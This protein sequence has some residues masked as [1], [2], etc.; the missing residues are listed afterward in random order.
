MTQLNVKCQFVK[1]TLAHVEVDKEDRLDMILTGGNSRDTSDN[2]EHVVKNMLKGWA[3]Y[4]D[5]HKARFGSGIGEDSF[6][7]QYWESMG[8]ALLALLNGEVGRLDCGDM[9][10][11]IRQCLTEEGFDG[12]NA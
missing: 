12:D 1:D 10:A 4:A 7:G 5:V 11:F 9:D 3:G 2:H 6:L 8:M